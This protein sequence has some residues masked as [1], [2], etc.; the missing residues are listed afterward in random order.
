MRNGAALAAGPFVGVAGGGL[1]VLAAL[2]QA[3]AGGVDGGA[4]VVE[5]AAGGDVGVAA[6]VE[7]ALVA[8]VAIG[9][10]HGEAALGVHAGGVGDFAASEAEVFVVAQVGIDG[11]AP[12]K[13][14]GHGACGLKEGFVACAVVAVQGG[15]KVAAGL[16]LAVKAEGGGAQAKGGV[17]LDEAIGV[18][19]VQGFA[20]IALGGQGVGDGQGAAG[21]DAALGVGSYA[22]IRYGFRSC[23]RMSGVR[24]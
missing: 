9:G 24:K 8:D 1:A 5:V 19:D 15:G 11:D 22:S 10:V 13:G 7:G 16:N 3:Q 6:A 20:G 18:G 21:L 14:E 4:F 2:G 17:G 12:G 23:L